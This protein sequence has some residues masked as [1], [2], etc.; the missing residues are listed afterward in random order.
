MAPLL[1]L[2][3][4]IRHGQTD[5]N[6]AARLQ[7]QADTDINAA[8]CAEADRNGRRLAGLVDDAAR[9]DFVASPLGRTRRTMARIRAA[10]GL[11]PEDYRL[12]PRILEVHFGD[13][14]GF[15]YDELEAREP[16]C[17]APRTRDKWVF[18]PPGAEA[19]SYAML[20]GR[21]AAWLGEIARP[22]VC[23]THGGVLRAVFHLV[24]GLAPDRAAGLTIPQNRL[25]RVED[26]RLDWL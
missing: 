17:T 18:C 7:G 3:Y 13:W 15:T 23:V 8:G 12:E 19:E 25:L 14:Q 26:G 5:W 1:P 24:G 21:V 20:A 10:M 6:A 11:A 9:F 16:G 22:T 4:M 2:V